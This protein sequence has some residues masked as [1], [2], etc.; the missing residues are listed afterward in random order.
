MVKNQQPHPFTTI[1]IFSVYK[2]SLVDLQRASLLMKV[3]ACDLHHVV[4]IR[5]REQQQ[6]PNT[7]CTQLLNVSCPFD[8]AP[9]QCPQEETTV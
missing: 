9:H 2:I 1:G 8:R 3:T 5:V 7:A 6:R 4:M